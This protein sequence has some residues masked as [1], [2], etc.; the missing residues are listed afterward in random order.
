MNKSKGSFVKAFLAGAGSLGV[1]LFAAHTQTVMARQAAAQTPPV[2]GTAAPGQTG[3]AAPAASVAAAQGAGQGS[4]QAQGQGR[5]RGGGF[6]EP[7][8]LNFD[9]HNGFVQIFDGKSLDGWE[10]DPAV[11][12][13][14][15]D[16]ASIVGISTVEHPYHSFISYKNLTAKDLDLKLEIKVEQGGG[17]GIQYR[18]KT[19]AWR[20]RPQNNNPNNPPPTNP[21]WLLT[22]P[23]AD[24]FFPMRPQV[25]VYTGQ[26]YTENSPMGIIAWRGEAVEMGSGSAPHLV[27]TIEDRRALGG[28]VKT[29]DWNQYEIIARGGTFIHI[30]NGQVMSVLVDDDAADV[31]NQPGVIGFEI[32]LAPS[33]VSVRNVWVKKF[34]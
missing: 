30:L 9:D 15:Q 13:V 16:S 19:G 3:A 29:N 4:G 11:W 27:G 8:P 2:A 32:E 7:E 23:Q 5:G 24:F 20:A 22:G 17:S 33:K 28:Y 34:N 31:N 18:S 1:L 14:D 12:H 10:Y 6:H 25:E 21:N 26:F